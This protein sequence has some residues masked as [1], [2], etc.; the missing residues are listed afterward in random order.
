[1]KPLVSVV[2][3]NY[4][5]P[6]DVERLLASLTKFYTV[7]H[8]VLVVDNGGPAQCNPDKLHELHGNLTHIVSTQNLGFGGGN[9]IAAKQAKGAYLWLLNSDTELVDDSCV[10]LHETLEA[11]SLTAISPLLYINRNCS[12]L[13]YD[14]LPGLQRLQT[15]LR[16]QAPQAQVPGTL[17]YAPAVSAAAMLVRTKDYTRIGGFDTRFFM[18]FEDLDLCLR[19]GGPIAT[20]GLARIYHAGGASM[21]SWARKRAY[22]RSQRLFWQKHHGALAA[23]LVTMLRAPVVVA[24]WLRNR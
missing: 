5:T 2:I 9:N 18:Y 14:A 11:S 1:M 21:E 4:R 15:L 19:L 8:E 23:V 10:H 17:T 3:V 24:S 6:N 16:R 20:D 22:Y 7:P 12:T 13:Q